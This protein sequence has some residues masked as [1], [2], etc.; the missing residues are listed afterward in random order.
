MLLL[1]GAGKDPHA[2]SVMRV[3]EEEVS[4]EEFQTRYID[5]LLRRG[6]ADKPLFRKI[7]TEALLAHKLVYHFLHDQGIA[8]DP[9]YRRLRKVVEDKLL[10][11]AYA[12]NMLYD[13]LEVSE[14]ELRELFVR[15]NT[16]MKARHLYAR[17]EEEAWEL[18]HR[19]QQGETF[20][21]LAR[22]VFRDTTLAHHGG[23]LGYFGFDEMDP[24]FEEAAFHLR[25]GEIS[26]PVR[27]AQGYSIIQLED[28]QVH[29]LLTEEAFVRKKHQLRAYLLKRKRTEARFQ[30]S[31]QVAR[32]I[33]PTFN[34]ASFPQLLAWIQKGPDAAFTEE[35]SLD[36]EVATYYHGGKRQ[37]WRLRDVLAWLPFTSEKQRHAVYDAY[38]LEQFLTGLLVRTVL[39]ARAH[40]ARLDTLPRYREALREV[41]ESR[42]YALARSRIA[43]TLALADSVL[44]AHFRAHRADYMTEP[45]RE[46]WE[47]V[48]SRKEEADSLMQLLRE[49]VN[50][51]LLAARHTIRPGGRSR[52]GYLGRVTPD[53]LGMLARFVMQAKEGELLGPVEIDGRFVILRVGATEVARYMTF[54]E[55]R[56]RIEAELREEA[57]REA[58]TRWIA[59]L[60]TRYPIEIYHERIAQMSLSI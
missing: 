35:A 25:I 11:E 10:L 29:P 57:L 60:K 56:P 37:V 16:R 58:F 17:T 13:T 18:Y 27:T 23:S 19:L 20:E 21:E 28:R 8:D 32:E 31:R 45:K 5:F 6:L 30:H 1:L 59:D 26:T 50:F 33:R 40:E 54:E 51:E 44:R 49:G 47:I 55:A 53:E 7:F 22:E 3:A 2:R 48:V 38:T 14:A 4:L 46:V 52:K 43:D 24:A 39:L 15:M 12:Q 42:L 34:R 41:M 36:T 9:A